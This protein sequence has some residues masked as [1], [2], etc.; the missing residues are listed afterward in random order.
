M[1]HHRTN[2]RTGRVG[3][4]RL[5]Q[6]EK[7]GSEPCW[8][9][10]KVTSKQTPYMETSRFCEDFRQRCSTSLGAFLLVDSWQII[11]SAL[12][13]ASLREMWSLGSGVRLR[14]EWCSFRSD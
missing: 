3:G 10:E 11:V 12:L 6:I 8:A 2:I 9:D 7:V 5:V 14:A 1:P 13:K 4:D